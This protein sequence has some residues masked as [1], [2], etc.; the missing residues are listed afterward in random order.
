MNTQGVLRQLRIGV[1]NMACLATDMKTSEKKEKMF[2]NFTRILSGFKA[3][4]VIFF[5]SLH[6]VQVADI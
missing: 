6:I 1:P 2:M 3:N 4:N 5:V